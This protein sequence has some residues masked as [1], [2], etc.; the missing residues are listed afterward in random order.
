MQVIEECPRNGGVDVSDIQGYPW[1]EECD[2]TEATE[3]LLGLPTGT[4]LVR[5]STKRGYAI[6]LRCSVCWVVRSVAMF[7]NAVTMPK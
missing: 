4:F 3:K 7:L 5:Y 1:Y 6:S 2:R